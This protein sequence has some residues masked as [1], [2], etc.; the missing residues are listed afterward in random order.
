RTTDKLTA[1]AATHLL[2]DSA[3]QRG[4]LVD[5]GIVSAD[6]CRVLADGSVSG[7]DPLR[8][9]PDA[10]L[11]ASVR[12]ELKLGDD[13]QVIV[14]IGRL[15]R[16]KGVVDLAKAFAALSIGFPRAALLLVGHDE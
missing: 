5:E 12:R 16:D 11:R 2:A 13:A 15:A 14:Y 8:F 4:F 6:K 10:E 9:R 1:H 3:S 7:V